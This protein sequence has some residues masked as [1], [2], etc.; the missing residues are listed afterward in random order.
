MIEFQ[1]SS[2]Q[3]RLWIESQRNP[4]SMLLHIH[5]LHRLTGKLDITLFKKCLHHILKNEIIF[6]LYFKVTSDI[7]TCVVKEYEHHHINCVYLH[8]IDNVCGVDEEISYIEKQAETPIN[9]LSQPTYRFVLYYSQQKDV[10]YFSAVLPHIIVDAYSGDL[11]FKRL[12]DLYNNDFKNCKEVR[13]AGLLSP[14]KQCSESFPVSA[15]YWHKKLSG[16]VFNLDFGNII[17]QGNS[18]ADSCFIREYFTSH[19]SRYDVLKHL[20]R[21]LRSTPFLVMMCVYALFLYRYTGQS[22]F[23]ILYPVD[24]R[25][26]EQKK[27]LGCYVNL[28]PLQFNFHKNNTLADIIAEITAQRKSDKQHECYPFSEIYKL[29]RR[30]QNG[31]FNVLLSKT[32]F[33]TNATLK[34]I[35]VDNVLLRSGHAECDLSFLFDVNE[36]EFVLCVEYDSNA[37]PRWFAKQ[38]LTCIVNSV[39][40]IEENVNQSIGAFP[41]MPTHLV[42]NFA[43][44]SGFNDV[45]TPTKENIICRL[46][47]A[48]REYSHHIALVNVDGMHKMRYAELEEQANAIAC[49]LKLLGIKKQA[50]VALLLPKSIH[51]V[52]TIIALAKLRCTFIPIDCTM[53]YDRSR[54]ILIDS[55]ARYIICYEKD[56][57]LCDDFKLETTILF[58]ETLLSPS[59]STCFK[60]VDT[61][62]DDIMYIIYTSGTTGKPKGVPIRY[63]AIDHLFAAADHYFDFNSSDIWS[64]SHS[65]AFDFSVW[66]MWGALLHGAQLL[67]IPR[68]IRRDPVKFYHLITEQQVT[69][70]NITPSAFKN[71]SR[72]DSEFQAPLNLR[73]LIFGGEKLLFSDVAAWLGRHGEENP[74]LINMYGLTEAPIHAAYHKIQRTDQQKGNSIVGKP[75]I[76]MEVYVVDSFGNVVPPGVYGEIWLSSPFMASG[77]L[78]SN[79]LNKEKFVDHVFFNVNKK[80]YKT[81]D[82]ACWLPDGRLN[83]LG[84]IDQQVQLNGYRIELSEISH[85]LQQVSLVDNAVSI[86]CDDNR[87]QKCII[88]F[89]VGKQGDDIKKCLFNY[90]KKKLPFY[91]IPADIIFIDEIPLTTQ[92]KVDVACLKKKIN[93]AHSISAGLKRADA[94]F[95]QGI[96]DAWKETLNVSEVDIDRNYFDA[97]GDSIS[98]LRLHRRLEALLGAS[99]EFNTLFHYTTI[100]SQAS[101]L[102]DR[103]NQ[104]TLDSNVALRKAIAV[105]SDVSNAQKDDIAIVGMALN[106]PGASNLGEFWENLKAGKESITFFSEETMHEQIKQ[107]KTDQKI[108]PAKGYLVDADCFDA[109]FFSYNAYEA[110]ILDPQ[111]RKLLECVW[112]ALENAG[113]ISESIAGKTGVFVGQSNL[114]SYYFDYVSKNVHAEGVSGDYQAL[115]H[116]SPDFLATRIAYQF[117]LTGPAM[118]VQTGCSTSLVAICQAAQ[119]LCDHQCDMAIAGGVAITLPLKSGYEYQAGMILSPDGHCRAFDKTASGTVPGNGVGVVILKRYSD[120]IAAKDSIYAVIKGHAV[121]NDGNHKIGFTAPSQVGQGDVIRAALKNAR[122]AADTIDYIEAHG[123]GT[124]LG[125][126]IEIE[127]LNGVMKD[128][129]A[130][131]PYVLGAVKTNIGHLDAASGVTGLIKTALCLHHQTWVPTLHFKT[132]NPKIRLDNTPFNII[133][134]TQRWK[135]KNYPR[136]AGVSSFAIGGANAHVIMQESKPSN[137]AIEKRCAVHLFVLSAQTVEALHVS[138]QQLMTYLDTMKSGSSL[139]NIAYTL[140]VGRE[141]FPYRAAFMAR[142]RNALLSQLKNTI[143]SSKKIRHAEMKLC[144]MF[145]GQGL[146]LCDE[147]PRFYSA[148][149]VFKEHI[150]LCVDTLIKKQNV[151]LRTLFSL[152]INEDITSECDFERVN[153]L[154]IFITEYALAKQWMAWGIYP[155][156]MIGH[157]LGEY[158]A[159][160]IAGVWSL[161]DALDIISKRQRLM[162]RLSLG[163][164]LAV[165]LDVDTLKKYSIE[166]ITVA[167]INSPN[168]CT[169]S[170]SKDDIDVLKQSL[171][172]D[173]VPY[174]LVATNHAYHSVAVESIQQEFSDYLSHIQTNRPSIP[175]ISNL[176]GQWLSDNEAMSPHYWSQQ[177]RET[178]LFSRGIETLINQQ[179]STFVELGLGH[180]LSTFVKQHGHEI[181]CYAPH[182]GAC[183]SDVTEAYLKVLGALWRAGIFIDWA[184][185]NSKHLASRIPLPTYPFEKKR[186]WVEETGRKAMTQQ[187]A[188]DYLPSAY[189]LRWQYQP[190]TTSEQPSIIEE[191]IYIVFSDETEFSNTLIETLQSLYCNVYIVK[192][193]NVFKSNDQTIE[194]RRHSLDDIDRVFEP[195]RKSD[196]L[197]I[198]YFWGNDL[199]FGAALDNPFCCYDNLSRYL[200]IL[201]VALSQ[202]VD[203]LKFTVI[204]D[205]LF[206]IDNGDCA[207][208]MN[209][210]LLGPG[211]TV[212][213][214]M[215]TIAHKIIELPLKLATDNLNSYVNL[216]IKD[217][218]CVQKEKLIAYRHKK[219]FTRQFLKL[220]FPTK[221]TSFLKDRGVYVITGGLGHVGLTIAEFL[222]SSCKATLILLSRRA[223]PSPDKWKNILDKNDSSESSIISVIKRLQGMQSELANVFIYQVDVTDY[224]ALAQVF[225]AIRKKQGCIDGIVHAAGIAGGN[226]LANLKLSD[227]DKVMSVKV[228][229]AINLHRLTYFDNLDFMLFC[230]AF[231]VHSGDYGQSIYN[232]S[233]AFLDAFAHWRSSRYGHTISVNWDTWVDGGMAKDIME[234]IAIDRGITDKGALSILPNIMS[235]H[236]CQLAITAND[237]V[238]RLEKNIVAACNDDFAPGSTC[239]SDLTLPTS[240]EI[241]NYLI[242]LWKRYLG[243]V[244]LTAT[245][246]FNQLGGDSLLAVQLA[247]VLSKHYCIAIYPHTLIEYSTIQQLSGHIA[248]QMNLKRGSIIEP[249]NDNF[250]LVRI[251]A[252]LE[253]KPNLFLIHPVGGTVHIYRDLAQSLENVATVYGLQAKALDGH[254]NPELSIP[255]MATHYINCI[256]KIQPKGEYNIGGASFGGLVAYEM[257][258]QLYRSGCQVNLLFMLD[259]PSPNHYPKTLPTDSDVIRYMLEVGAQHTPDPTFETCSL[260][261]Q[262]DYFL[263]HAGGLGKS[264]S[265]FNHRHLKRFL[266]IYQCNIK[267]MF[268]YKPQPPS[269]HAL[270]AHFYRALKRD[271]INPEHPEQGWKDLLGDKL[272]VD[273]TLGNHITMLFNPYVRAIGKS[274]TQLIDERNHCLTRATN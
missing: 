117:N 97:G 104:R 182:L 40:S 91:M 19:R 45:K 204:T 144:F 92:K 147:L 105:S 18:K 137:T 61:R 200:S 157:S 259:T 88:T 29:A 115:I 66:E 188:D 171:Q 4:E 25:N 258:Q 60:K 148:L 226:T 71:F 178:V 201:K 217:L 199:S 243:S 125:D 193:G 219:R 237:V 166:N 209:S 12:A 8:D 154:Y 156:G 113:Y 116:N 83:F 65:M 161:G 244:N 257:A 256:K 119:S 159:A 153:Q 266:E 191:S 133:T 194:I 1:L 261:E 189:Q 170:G 262:L 10:F 90:I 255:M 126:P 202:P 5:T 59:E 72:S 270:N 196:C 173:A 58:V 267:A 208:P 102:T 174:C 114:S 247:S 212:H 213:N 230:S 38:L 42:K 160:C 47:H 273:N 135:K 121:N 248:K 52:S 172:A 89:C 67:L 141:H 15:D 263:K 99:I 268:S 6:N 241:E 238:T 16:H 70:C 118:T 246:D 84:R 265:E 129:S 214:E 53:P 184:A 35:K 20:A 234:R 195:F 87:N 206:E 222:S 231:S 218:A 207:N 2:E 197:H 185:F 95:I 23:S 27:S 7:P 251:N 216:V 49:K 176:T 136:R 177:M 107:S 98:L 139:C 140:Q 249:E 274:L 203:V 9:L 220:S 103:M 85:A 253:E 187:E 62:L 272:H 205:S 77:Y 175:F 76:E 106:V 163:C 109:K 79:A 82:Y 210:L 183:N 22:E 242:A 239:P 63:A 164:M 30:Y 245:D 223:F 11:L 78:N 192:N 108:V 13:F 271:A 33:L 37:L 158:V 73:Y 155:T 233:N 152:N 165:S 130:N 80:L 254:S 240:K 225:S 21:R 34:D 69:I 46:E 24:I 17:S 162:N 143:A 3:T 227:I 120:A 269:H 36:F 86:V 112:S 235:Y 228:H 252:L 48:M 124:T 39:D 56:A 41:I 224:N 68:S 57:H 74:A 96:S 54:H 138:C 132:L 94:S 186:Y 43:T 14:T 75:L 111:H 55:G 215:P 229:G 31:I 211:L 127:A 50:R 198:I 100:R 232:S 236:G 32:R 131:K 142:S 180:H 190:A 260:E 179:F 169:L 26:K 101:Y 123:T 44:N 64:L 51:M 28:L 264:L 181:E 150:T 221:H 145:P 250:C 122:I 134:K 151:D 128:R 146:T 93:Q 149:P 110:T 167:A 168:R 81:G